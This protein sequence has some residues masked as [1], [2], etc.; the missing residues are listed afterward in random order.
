MLRNTKKRFDVRIQELVSKVKFPGGF[1]RIFFL[2]S[3]EMCPEVVLLTWIL[4]PSL[5]SDFIA[6]LPFS[7]TV[8]EL[9]RKKTIWGQVTF[10]HFSGFLDMRKKSLINPP[11]NFIFENSSWILTSNQFFW[12]IS[13]YW[14]INLHLKCLPVHCD[15]HYSDDGCDTTDNTDNLQLCQ[16]LFF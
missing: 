1:F 8:N 2:N 10:P 4:A 5:K 9:A 7:P 3:P 16:F 11:G 12:C 15:R 13:T 6:T 14:V